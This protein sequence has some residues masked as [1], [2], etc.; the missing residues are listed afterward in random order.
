MSKKQELREK[1]AKQ[2]K[3]NR[4]I[5]LA[6]IALGAIVIALVLILPTLQPVGDFK[7]PVLNPRP[8]ANG[9]SMGDPNAPV[10]MEEYADFQ[11]P[12]CAAFTAQLEPQ[13][14]EKYIATGKVYF[15]FK[16][17][18]FID[19]FK[20][21]SKESKNAA[22]AA[23]CAADQNKFW[24]YRDILFVN[25]TG[26][27]VGDFSDKRLVA[28]AEKLGLDAGTFKSCLNTGKYANRVTQERQEGEDLGVSGTPSFVVNGKLLDMGNPQ[29][30]ITAI[31]AVL[32]GK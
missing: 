18:A 1:R 32:A 9:V 23:F 24:E 25:Q 27:N 17:F 12:S 22:Q 31:D 8:N 7:V 20:P 13:I 21:P 3:R 28:F 11:C 26:E 4:W 16:S 30:V 6:L 14:V 10:K 19:E 29:N 15:T 5:A 2:E